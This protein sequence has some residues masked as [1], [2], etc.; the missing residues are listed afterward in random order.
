M[1]TLLIYK[2]KNSPFIN[3]WHPTPMAWRV[4]KQILSLKLYVGEKKELMD[5]EGTALKSIVLSSAL[6]NR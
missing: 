2:W 4:S 5:K 6:P 1:I 3:L